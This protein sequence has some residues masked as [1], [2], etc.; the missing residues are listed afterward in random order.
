MTR[1]EKIRLAIK[2][3][4]T[5]DPT[6]GKVYSPYKKELKAKSSQGYTYI[7]IIHNKKTHILYA[8]QFIFYMVYG[9]IVDCIDH[10]N[11]LVDDNR[12]ENIR[13]V[14]YKQNQHNQKKAKGYSKSGKKWNSQITI[15][16]KTISL[17]RYDTE[18][19]AHQAYINAKKIYHII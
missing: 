8:H 14:T 4:I 6:T 5:C 12:I 13:S 19:E 3:G 2:K 17:G 16:S 9:K 10:I 15:D 7:S 18:Q 11:G 1:E